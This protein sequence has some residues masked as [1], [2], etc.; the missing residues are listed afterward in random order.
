[1]TMLTV[2]EKKT[3]TTCKKATAWLDSRGVAYER[4]DI[5]SEPPPADLL[6][7]A[8]DAQNVKASLNSRASIYREKKLG[9]NVPSKKEAI[10]LMQQDPNLIKRPLIVTKDGKLSMGFDEKA[11]AGFL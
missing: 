3:C 7:R 5:V 11:L 9:E 8:I 6:E 2:Y 4:K 10:R 1:M